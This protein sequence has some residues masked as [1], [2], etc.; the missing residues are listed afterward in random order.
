ML[1]DPPAKVVRGL[2]RVTAPTIVTGMTRWPLV[3]AEDWCGDHPAFH[4]QTISVDA[5]TPVAGPEIE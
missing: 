5:P 2:C 1:P 3:A 4:D